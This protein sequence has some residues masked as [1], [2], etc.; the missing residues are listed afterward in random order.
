M[1]WVV[2]AAA[3]LGLATLVAA[4]ATGLRLFWI[5]TPVLGIPVQVSYPP[6][7]L[8]NF[9]YLKDNWRISKMHTRLMW[10]RMMHLIFRRPLA[11]PA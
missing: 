3:A 10:R 2:A 4:R 11:L 1:P 5:G 6:G 9:D 8:S 7:N